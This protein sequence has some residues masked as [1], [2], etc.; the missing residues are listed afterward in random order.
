LTTFKYIEHGQ[1]IL[2]AANFVFEL[3]DG[4]GISV[5][6]PFFDLLLDSLTTILHQFI[7][8]TQG[9]IPEIL[10]KKY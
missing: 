9:P 1:K 2:N 6:R 4:L 8:L 5:F 7:L 3:A 10:D